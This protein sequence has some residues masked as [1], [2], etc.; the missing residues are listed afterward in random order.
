VTLPVTTAAARARA[1]PAS[2]RT[3]SAGLCNGR[4]ARRGNPHHGRLGRGTQGRQAA[5]ASGWHFP[6]IYS[7]TASGSPTRRTQRSGSSPEGGKARQVDR[8][9]DAEIRDYAW[10]PDGR[11][12]AYSKLFPASSPRSSS[13]TR[14]NRRPPVTGPYTDD[15][16]PRGIPKALP[17]LPQ[18]PLHESA[19]RRARLGQHRRAR[20]KPYMLLCGRREE[21]LRSA[22][23]L[24]AVEDDKRRTRRSQ[25]RREGREEE[26]R[27]KKDGEKKAEARKRRR[28]RSRSPSRSTSTDSPA[29]SRAACSAGAYS[30]LG[31]TASRCFTS[32]RRS[33]H[34]RCRRSSTNR[35]PTAR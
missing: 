3:A 7:P 1:G 25:V 9:G 19:A 34:A 30:N 21:P 23:G 4:A 22:G 13:T 29:G 11:F 27:D 31:C 15:R 18:R 16:F 20:V 14:R 12:L 10:S 24:P 32:R 6:P 35:R 5:G 2:R 28:T 26:G 33:R 17:V 8:S